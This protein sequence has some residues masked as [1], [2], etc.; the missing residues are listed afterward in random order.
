MNDDWNR[1]C[2][3]RPKKFRIDKF[4]VSNLD[5][6]MD[7]SMSELCFNDSF[8]KKV[9]ISS[10]WFNYCEKAFSITILYRNI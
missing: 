8:Q 2:E 1:Q 4:H 3:K 9:R 6:I 5:K 7:D 10:L